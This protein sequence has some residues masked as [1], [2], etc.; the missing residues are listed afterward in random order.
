MKT[1]QTLIFSILL[2][3]LTAGTQLQAQTAL[4]IKGG[5][6][7][8]NVIKKF[9]AGMDESDE[10]TRLSVHFGYLMR[11]YFTEHLYF[12]P[13]LLYM[14]KG[15]RGD[16]TDINGIKNTTTV[17]FRNINLPLLL[18]VQHQNFQIAVGP[19]IE[20]FLKAHTKTN[21]GDFSANPF[22]GK[23]TWLINAN[24]ELGYQINQLQLSIRGSLGLTPFLEG[25]VTDV[26]GVAIG[27][28]GYRNIAVQAA[29][30]YLIFRKTD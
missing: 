11:T 16:Y 9:P 4:G 25:E 27:E 23:N 14:E 8:S 1:T 7:L 6:T 12:Q 24:L 17:R 22:F 5:L 15:F 29:V 2:V 26:N 10:E 3:L 21:N 13:E 19:E 20:Y 28:F 18:G 30:A